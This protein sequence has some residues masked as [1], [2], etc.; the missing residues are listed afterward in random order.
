VT[1]SA[2]TG[3]T[4]GPST[5]QTVAA[6][7]TTAFVVT[8]DAGY[9]RNAAV[10]GTCPQGSW[11][12][13]TWTTGAINASC[14]ASFSFTINT[15]TSTN[16]ALAANGGV[17]SASSTISGRS[18]ASTIDNERA[19]INFASTGYGGIW[20][21]DTLDVYPD[22]VQ[23]NF[24]GSKTIDRVVV[25]T[26]QTNYTAPVEPTD[27]MTTT[28][29]ITDF[30]VAGW[31]GTAWITLATVT[32][33]T[34]VKR[35]VTFSEFATDRI[36]VIITKALE[37]QSRIAEIEAWTAVGPQLA[38]GMPGVLEKL[39]TDTVNLP[40]VDGLAFDRFGNLFGVLE[41]VSAAGGVVYIDKA[42]GAVQPIALN[43]PGACRLDVH[44]NGDVYVSSEL[45]IQNINGVDV[46]LGGLYRVVLTYDAANRPVSGVATKQGSVLNSPEGIQP[47]PADSAYG[48]AGSMFI[49][50]DEIGGRI[51]R[52]QPDGSGLTVLVGA[53]AN[54]QKPEGLAFGN[55]NGA[56]GAA[57][58]AAEKAG[59]RIMRIGADGSVTT[60]GN[61]ATVGGLNGPD[62]IAFG[63]DG[64][65]YVGEK[66]GGRIIRIAA[67][68]RHSVYATGFDNV[69]GVAFD[70]LT[71]HLYIGEI[72]KSTIWR[73]RP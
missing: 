28:L 17:P 14:T 63:P 7:A 49:A 58:Y 42:T 13:N 45:P 19:G 70:P 21:D 56:L 40:R 4:V 41:V 23:I 26:A 20:K 73:V 5:T 33:N 38:P 9:T 25:Y 10:G 16:V 61:P 32:G 3:G 59:G 62:N 47:L 39:V 64:Y 35:T 1:P 44:P 50:E 57:L 67:D 24:N 29:G 71:G 46:Q 6:G 2:G 43:I 31:N 52:V 34:L 18:P 65:L 36:R 68:G 54:L 27:A 66:Y 60:F 69:E 53:A 48:N 8:A 30:T 51:V 12:G 11:N 22:W 55:F 72:E 15:A 37:S